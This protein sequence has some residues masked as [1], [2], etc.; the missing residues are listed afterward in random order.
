MTNDIGLMDMAG[1]FKIKG[2]I[3]RPTEAFAGTTT[4]TLSVG[5]TGDLQR[6]AANYDVMQAANLQDSEPSYL[7]DW[8]DVT[9]IRLSAISTVEN[10]DQTTAGIV[11]V[12]LLI[13]VIK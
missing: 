4:Y 8:N 11:E 10:L 7:E 5:I 12:R 9:S 2:V 6:Y 3:I 1:G 13:D